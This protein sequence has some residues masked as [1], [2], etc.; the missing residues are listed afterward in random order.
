MSRRTVL[1][2]FAVAAALA[3][4]AG[5]PGA[6]SQQIFADAS[7]G[8][9]NG[10]YSQADL[11]RASKDATVQGYGNPIIKITI[12]KPPLRQRS[13][14]PAVRRSSTLPLTGSN[15]ATFASLGLMLL[16]GG[17]LLRLMARRRHGR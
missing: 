7:D 6:T 5:A 15:L 14:T 3:A 10:K 11:E 13:Q 4:P 9:L 1:A 8:H 12:F 17:L 16:S 2:G